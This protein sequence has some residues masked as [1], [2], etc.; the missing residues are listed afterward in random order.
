MVDSASN[1]N[2][3]HE[4]LLGDKGG[5]CIVLTKL[6]PSCTDC[7]KILGSSNCWSPKDLSRPVTG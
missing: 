1:G 7:L 6:P 5:R 4:Y 2:E 3:Y